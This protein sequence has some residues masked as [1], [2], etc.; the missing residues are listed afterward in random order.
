MLKKLVLLLSLQAVVSSGTAL[1]EAEQN[2]WDIYQQAVAND[3]SLA[4][5]GN[6]NKAAQELIAQAKA[7]YRPDVN[8][9][10]GV[11]ATHSDI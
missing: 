2:L 10:A 3:P 1:A 7:L 5:A 11:S 6:Q 9:N 8:F 4:A